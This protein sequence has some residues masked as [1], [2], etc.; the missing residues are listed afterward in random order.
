M[1]SPAPLSAAYSN[2]IGLTAQALNGTLV[3]AIVIDSSDSSI[4]YATQPD[5]IAIIP[6][7]DYPGYD[8]RIPVA[9]PIQPATATSTST[10]T[11]S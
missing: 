7:S 5:I 8:P 1:R 9:I 6:E 4:I 11:T 10:S 3:D 2:G